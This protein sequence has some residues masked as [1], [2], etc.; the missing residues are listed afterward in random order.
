MSEQNANVFAFSNANK[1]D[2]K[3]QGFQ[4]INLINYYIA[5]RDELLVMPVTVAV[6]FI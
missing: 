3:H 2:A 4:R 1:L 6:L 5:L